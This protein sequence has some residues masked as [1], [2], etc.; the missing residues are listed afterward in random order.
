MPFMVTADDTYYTGSSLSY[1][2]EKF[3]A[4]NCNFMY[5][6]GVGNYYA[7]LNNDQWDSTLNCG[8]CAEVSSDTTSVTVYIVDKCDECEDEGLGLSP[9]VFNQ[10]T[11]SDS[12]SNTSWKFVDCPVRGSI[13]YCANSLSTN[14]WLALQPANSVTGVA[15]MK[16]DNQNTTVADTG[17]YFVLSKVDMSAVNIE[18]TSI[19]GETIKETLSLSAGNCTAGTSNF[20]ASTSQQNQ[21]NNAFDTLKSGSSNDDSYKAGKVAPPDD[22][23]QTI[24]RSEATSSGT[25]LLFI[26]PALLIV[27]GGI[28]MAA[29]AY[30]IKK[31]KL[32]DQS[33]D[34]KKS[35]FG[36]LNSPV[37]VK[38]TIAKI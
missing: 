13:E 12:S 37:Q 19:S 27:V 25:S 23:E 20:Q 14:S 28:V 6:P 29:V 7:A 18:L 4:G 17:Y 1:T 31:K 11:R 2:H 34:R 36:T 32:I 24:T 10:L 8:R 21:V 22:E 15:S 9:L 35:S 38:E 30:M 16:I 5:D 3:S 26:V 33:I